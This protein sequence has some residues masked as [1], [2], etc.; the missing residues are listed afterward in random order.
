[1]ELTLPN[2]ELIP[3]EHCECTINVGYQEPVWFYAHYPKDPMI[4]KESKFGKLAMDFTAVVVL[5]QDCVTH[6]GV[7]LVTSPL[8]LRIAE[9]ERS[10][11]CNAVY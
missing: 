7:L 8:Q 9:E 3:R 5:C 10:G 11:C 1:L 4:I 2:G 6:D